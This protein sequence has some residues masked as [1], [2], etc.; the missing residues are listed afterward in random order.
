MAN[1][2]SKIRKCIWVIYVLNEFWYL[3]PRW[4]KYKTKKTNTQTNKQTNKQQTEPKTKQNQKQNNYKTNKTKKLL[5]KKKSSF[6]RRKLSRLH[7]T[8]T[9]LQNG[10]LHLPEERRNKEA[11]G[12]FGY[13]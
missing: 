11:V 3:F 5:S 6:F 10:K 12:L 13:P 7:K 8:E 2:V 9:I 1:R 4:L